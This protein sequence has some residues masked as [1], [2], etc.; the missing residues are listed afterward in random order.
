MELTLIMVTENRRV[1]E[2]INIHISAKRIAWKMSCPLLKGALVGQMSAGL[3]LN[4]ALCEREVRF[5]CTTRTH[6]DI[7]EAKGRKPTRIMT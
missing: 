6:A 5:V 3:L 2:R 7:L 1:D 4:L